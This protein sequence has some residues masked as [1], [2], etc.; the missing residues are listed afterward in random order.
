M[1]TALKLIREATKCHPSWWG[2]AAVAERSHIIVESDALVLDINRAHHGHKRWWLDLNHGVIDHNGQLIEALNDKR[3]ERHF[4]YPQPDRLEAVR[5]GTGISVE[6]ISKDF[7]LY[8]GT[9]FDHFGHLL[10]DLNRTYQL[11]RLFRDHKDPI[12]FHYHRLR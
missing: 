10:L 12:W 5:S 1:Q 7:V 3:G 4:F 2:K 9:L 8:G 6:P 11:L